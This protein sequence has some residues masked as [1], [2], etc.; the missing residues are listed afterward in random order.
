MSSAYYIGL[1][2]SQ[3]LRFY[4]PSDDKARAFV[5]R[6]IRLFWSAYC[7][8]RP[9]GSM[10]AA[11]CREAK[12]VVLF[13]APVDGAYIVLITQVAQ[14]DSWALEANAYVA[15]RYSRLSRMPILPKTKT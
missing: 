1:V 6:W 15:T 14:I 9:A 2:G 4:A 5:A 3:E 8:A 13:R 7:A 11:F 12:E 10:A